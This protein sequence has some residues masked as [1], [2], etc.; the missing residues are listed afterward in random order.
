MGELELISIKD[1]ITKE[2]DK[3][4]SKQNITGITDFLGNELVITIPANEVIKILI[5]GFPDQFRSA[6]KIEAGDIK[7]RIKVI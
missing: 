4:L 2:I 3:E 5:S 1:L 6:V 7:I